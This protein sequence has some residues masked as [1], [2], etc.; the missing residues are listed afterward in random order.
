MTVSK[1]TKI[2][3]KSINNQI[4][5]N[6]IDFKYLKEIWDKF[7][8]ISAKIEQRVVY[9]IFYELFYY[10]KINKPKGYKNCIMQIFIKEKN[11][12]KQF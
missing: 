2:I 7:K 11:S 5:F 1:T 9:L 10:L 6:I 3:G 12:Y 4:A 8:S